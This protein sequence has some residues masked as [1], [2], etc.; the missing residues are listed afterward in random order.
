VTLVRPE[1]AA[2]DP[3]AAA[4]AVATPTILDTRGVI[5]AAQWSAARW[6]VHGLGRQP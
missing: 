4:S 5:I 1:F 2:V 3:H 6:T